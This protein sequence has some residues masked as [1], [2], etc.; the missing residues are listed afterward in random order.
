MYMN[1]KEK[2]DLVVTHFLSF[3]QIVNGKPEN[4]FL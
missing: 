2:R 4:Q 1:P 3:G